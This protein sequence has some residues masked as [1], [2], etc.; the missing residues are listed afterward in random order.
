[1]VTDLAITGK[2]AQFGRGVIQDVC[3]KL[4]GQF[5]ACL[6]QKVG[7]AAEEL[8]AEPLGGRGAAAAAGRRAAVPLRRRRP[9]RPLG[10]RADR[11]PRAATPA[12]ASTYA[13]AVRGPELGGGDD[14]LDLGAT[15]LPILVKTYWK[16]LAGGAAVVG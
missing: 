7:A 2:P 4:L 3:D 11:M 8:P 12:P 13:G 5:I 1:M 10:R 15:V 6:E 14:A 16:Q 9:R